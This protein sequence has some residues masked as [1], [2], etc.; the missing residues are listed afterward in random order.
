M[1]KIT[2]SSHDAEFSISASNSRLFAEEAIELER[3]SKPYLG[4]DKKLIV[5][6]TGVR[7]VDLSGIKVLLNLMSEEV[8]LTNCSAHILKVI[9]ALNCSR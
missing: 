4:P 1:F 2:P 7:F 5:D 9:K 6:L 3:V 8:E